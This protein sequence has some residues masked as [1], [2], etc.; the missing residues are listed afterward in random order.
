MVGDL[1]F[2]LLPD[3]KYCKSFF[4]PVRAQTMNSKNH[5]VGCL[6]FK[7]QDCTIVVSKLFEGMHWHRKLQ[8]PWLTLKAINLR[9]K[10]FF[11][12]STQGPPSIYLLDLK[13]A[14]RGHCLIHASNNSPPLRS[15]FLSESPPP[16]SSKWLFLWWKA[17][18]H[19]T[20]TVHNIYIQV[21]QNPKTLS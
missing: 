10:I 3:P 8:N 15:F 19:S 13:V 20:S 5:P 6:C 18:I 7:R 14:N 12:I 11:A 16:F 4:P 1:I 2:P 17:R 9:K 21:I